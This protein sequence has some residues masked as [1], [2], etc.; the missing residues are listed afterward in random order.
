MKILDIG[1]THYE[2]ALRIQKKF[3]EQKVKYPEREDI[4]ILTEHFPVYTLGKTSKK[5]HILNIPEGIPVYTVERGGSVTFHGEGQIVVYPV[6]H[7]KGKNRSVKNFVWTLEE[8]MIRT[9]QE[10]GINGFRL[11]KYRGVFTPKGKIGFVGIKISRNISYHGISLNVDLD[12]SFFGKIV[13]CGIKD[14]PVCNIS[15]FIEDVDFE[16]VKKI[17][18]K[19]IMTML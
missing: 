12:K 7:L 14:I 6:I 9:V 3:F 17:L 15:D 18:I 11:D 16:T 2:D 4:V 8:I 10:F 19:N 13:P 5:E 1:K